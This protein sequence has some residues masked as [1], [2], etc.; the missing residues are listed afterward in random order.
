MSGTG[1]VQTVEADTV[2]PKSGGS[3]LQ[4]ARG[5]FGGG[6]KPIGLLFA[7]EVDG[8]VEVMCQYISATPKKV[9]DAI[10]AK[11]SVAAHEWSNSEKEKA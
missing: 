5:E 8:D 2:K 1:A 9:K 6:Y 4:F 7:R 11:F 10:V 3:G